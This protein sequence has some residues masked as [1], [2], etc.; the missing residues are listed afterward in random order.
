MRIKEDDERR[1]GRS[2]RQQET[3]EILAA[4]GIIGFLLVLL[5]MQVIDAWS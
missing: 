2:V 5:V 4:I 1:Q 3:N